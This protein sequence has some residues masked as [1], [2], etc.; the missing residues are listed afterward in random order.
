MAISDLTQKITKDARDKSADIAAQSQDQINKVASET[1]TLTQSKR[2]IF[3]RELKKTL[4]ANI[5]KISASAEQEAKMI[6]DE[7]KRQILNGTFK[8]ALKKLQSISDKD[9]EGII[10][11]LLKTIKETESMVLTTPK[12]RVEITKKALTSLKLTIPV[13]ETKDI[14]GGFIMTGDNFEYNFSF[15][16]IIS[17]KKN[18]LEIDVANILFA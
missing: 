3:T 11:K 2:E 9:Y 10:V 8:E 6:V 7:K 17:D 4:E 14:T 15:E 1:E 16:K 13:K 5:K 18:Q 12:N